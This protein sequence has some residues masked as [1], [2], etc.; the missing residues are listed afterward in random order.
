MSLEIE[1]CCVQSEAS[2]RQS[3]ASDVCVLQADDDPTQYWQQAAEVPCERF[4]DEIQE[5]K[6]KHQRRSVDYEQR[7]YLLT[8]PSV[9]QWL[10]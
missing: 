1:D 7:S 8:L 9:F 4:S 6:A 10:A 2:G 5:A 3:E